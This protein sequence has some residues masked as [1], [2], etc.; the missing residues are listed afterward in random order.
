[1]PSFGTQKTPKA[2]SPRFEPE[3]R[4]FFD[5]VRRPFLSNELYADML[6]LWVRFSCLPSEDQGWRRNFIVQLTG[7]REGWNE[8]IRSGT[9]RLVEL[10]REDFRC[11]LK[12]AGGDPLRFLNLTG[13]PVSGIFIK[14]EYVKVQTTARHAIRELRRSKKERAVAAKAIKNAASYLDKARPF[15]DGYL[16]WAD[17]LSIVPERLMPRPPWEVPNRD[18]Y[19]RGDWL[20]SIAWIIENAD[21]LG[22]IPT[23][24][25]RKGGPPKDMLGYAAHELHAVCA[26]EMKR[27]LEEERAEERRLKILVGEKV[28]LGP[29]TALLMAAFPEWFRRD[30]NPVRNVRNALR[31]LRSGKDAGL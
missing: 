14:M 27:R 30:S 5:L 23:G 7:E 8:I 15:V 28:L 19:P 18:Q 17:H 22:L 2:P 11:L 6:L 12:K 3:R 9:G 10:E 1:M 24:V 21:K 26:S 4:R 20:R 29:L 25:N 31:G 16:W 13:V